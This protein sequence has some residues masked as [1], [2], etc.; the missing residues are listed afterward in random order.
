MSEVIQASARRERTRQRL[1][2]AAAEVFA[3]EG[4]DAA[5]VEA[6]CERAGFTRGAFY[7]NF[8]SK[9]ELFFEL[10]TRVSNEKLSAVTAR[11]RELEA[12][13]DRPTHPAEI[14][15]RLLDFETDDR[16]GVLILSEIRNHSLRDA[17]LS[18]SYLAWEDAMSARVARVIE[19]VA[20]SSGLAPRMSADELARLFLMTWESASQRAVMMGLDNEA[21]CAAVSDRMRALAEALVG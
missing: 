19:D 5:S 6:I 9:D 4:L 21:L 10:A 11:L 20:R 12:S 15:G 1:L 17:T 13:T 8:E 14:V 3:E 16:L 18:A 2:D 7:S